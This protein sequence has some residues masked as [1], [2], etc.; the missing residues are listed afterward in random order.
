[1]IIVD[2]IKTSFVNEIKRTAAA[3]GGKPLG[4]QRFEKRRPGYRRCDWYGKHWRNWGETLAEAGFS[5][6]EFQA[7]YDEKDLLS[8]FVEL[9]RELGRVPDRSKPANEG[10][11]GQAIPQSQLV[12]HASGLDLNA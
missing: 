5:P 7:A 1:M 11:A 10:S 9:I 6:N 3:N 4:M 12:S 8:R 2:E